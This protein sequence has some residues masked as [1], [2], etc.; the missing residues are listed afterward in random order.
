MPYRFMEDP[1]HTVYILYS[2]KLRRHYIG[3]SS[4]IDVRMEFH[5]N[6]EARKFTAKA[7]EWEL[8]FEIK[9]KNKLQGLAIEKHIK[10]MK[11]KVYIQNLK[12]YPEMTENLLKKYTSAG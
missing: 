10:S 4:D 9:C 6:A 11:S 7:D 2:Q 5:K 1:L 8:F 3:Y 12:K